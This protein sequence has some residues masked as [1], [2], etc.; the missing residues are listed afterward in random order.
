MS[1][2]GYGPQYPNEPYGQPQ[3]PG[4]QYPGQQYPGGQQGGQYP[5]GQQGG[6]YPGGQPGGQYGEQYGQPQYPGQQ[7]GQ[8]QYPGG[9]YGD[10]HYGA[11]P[12][13]PGRSRK[14]VFIG[15]GAVVVAGL[16]V[17]VLAVTGVFSGDTATGTPTQPVQALLE[18][19]RSQDLTGVKA[20]LCAGDQNRSGLE[21]SVGSNRATD[22]TVG[23]VEQTQPDA[24]L[25][26]ATVTTAED[27]V[28]IQF[29]VVKENGAWKVCFS[30]AGQPGL[31]LTGASTPSATPPSYTVP[32]LTA[33]SIPTIPSL[34][35]PSLSAPSLSGLGSICAS[36]KDAQSTARLFISAIT[37][38]SIDLAEGCVYDNRVSRAR[39]ESLT[40]TGRTYSPSLPTTDQ[41]P[42]FT[43]KSVSGDHTLRVTVEKQSDGK[44]YVV[45][46]SES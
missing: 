6:Q 9:Q 41:G 12:P 46:A 22:F 23:S 16:A 34:S 24:A 40:G 18:A 7:Y 28:D 38:S 31:G 14:G 10:Q 37:L 17:L 39:I 20:N 35:A 36:S 42:T 21:D 27:T 26:N 33:P 15:L 13:N 5:G 1:D 19:S 25:V 30:R 4:Q 45:D 2:Q 44:Y 29:P 8:P 3:Y 32:S 43:V 11:P